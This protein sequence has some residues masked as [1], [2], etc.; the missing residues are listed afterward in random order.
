MEETEQGLLL[1][2]KNDGKMSWEAT[3]KAMAAEQE[4]W[5][6]FDVAVLDCNDHCSCNMLANACF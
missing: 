4:D 5:S 2:K 6:D 3:F 1:R